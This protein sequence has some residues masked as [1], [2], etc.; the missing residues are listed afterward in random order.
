MT[1]ESGCVGCDASHPCDDCAKRAQASGEI[2]GMEDSRRTLPVVQR[3][4]TVTGGHRAVVI[5]RTHAPLHVPA[6]GDMDEE[7][8]AL[9][10]S[11]RDLPT[12]R[13]REAALR[14]FMAAR[15]ASAD[16]TRAAVAA[17]AQG[18]LTTLTRYLNNNRE[19]R[20]AELHEN[21]ETA[22]ARIGADVQRE[23]EEIQQRGE[24]E[25]RRLELEHGVTNQG[26]GG[27]DSN[28]NQGGGGGDS[29]PNQGGGD[30]NPNQGGGDSNP[31]QGGGSTPATGLST[32]AKVAIGVAGGAVVL[33]VGYLLWQAAEN[34]RREEEEKRR[35]DEEMRLR[36]L[37][38]GA[39]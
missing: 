16:Q 15:Q 19:E 14:S 6:S 35:R 10:D 30:S 36:M 31:N 3:Q 37:Q 21:G 11:I 5:E 20:L 12:A 28:P 29:N 24:T 17:L 2:D 32:G 13:E 8:Q 34:R 22:R 4:R 23:L 25:R 26:G 27:G 7:D 1:A 18:G 9:L 33:T 39:R 38:A